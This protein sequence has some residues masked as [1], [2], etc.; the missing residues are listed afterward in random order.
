MHAWVIEIEG[1]TLLIYVADSGFNVT[2]NGHSSHTESCVHYNLF[3]SNW[4]ETVFIKK[5]TKK[6]RFIIVVDIIYKDVFNLRPLN[7]TK[8][9]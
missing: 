6:L 8:K 1:L 3:S 9:R 4:S 7:D 2:T 5:N